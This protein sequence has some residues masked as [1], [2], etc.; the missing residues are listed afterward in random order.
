MPAGLRTTQ[1]ESVPS[2]EFDLTAPKHL[3]D[4]LTLQQVV[5]ESSVSMQEKRP[6]QTPAQRQAARRRRLADAGF[7][8]IKVAVPAK[9]H[10]RLRTLVRRHGQPAG[11]VVELALHALS[12]KA[13]S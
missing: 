10:E 4:G 12:E 5:T 9:V 6:P 3:G 1:G 2:P 11:R 13:R 8:T 7:T